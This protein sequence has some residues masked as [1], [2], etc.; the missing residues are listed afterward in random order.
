[1]AKRHETIFIEREPPTANE[2][3]VYDPQGDSAWEGSPPDPRPNPG[4]SITL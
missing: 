4:H 1:M 3:R 2:R